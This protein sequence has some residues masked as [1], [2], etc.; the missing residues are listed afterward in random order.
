MMI[1]R[2]GGEAVAE[3]FV[4][5]M[6][7][8]ILHLQPSPKFEAGAAPAHLMSAA[9]FTNP[10]LPHHFPPRAVTCDKCDRTRVPLYV[11]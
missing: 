7:M 6:Q 3:L 9:T 2:G 4:V 1:K 10:E 8:S 11:S 5:R